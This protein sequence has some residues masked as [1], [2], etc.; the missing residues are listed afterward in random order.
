MRKHALMITF[1]AIAGCLILLSHGTSAQDANGQPL[2]RKWEYKVVH[3]TELVG[4]ANDLNDLD[5]IITGFE[6]SLNDLGDDGWELCLE[7]NG[8]VVLKRPQ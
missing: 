2:S 3:I 6:N 1:A 7:V 8:G 4:G 5:G